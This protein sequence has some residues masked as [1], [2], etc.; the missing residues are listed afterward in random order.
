MAPRAIIFDFDDTL[1][2]HRGAS[3]AAIADWVAARGA[4]GGE[5]A[6]LWHDA[7]NRHVAAWNRGE[8]SF[9]GQRRRRVAEMLLALG[10]PSREDH[11]LDALYDEFLE[12]YRR[13]WRV[14]D[15]VDTTLQ[16]LVD[17]PIPFAVLTNG[18]E[19]LQV[20]K[21]ATVGLTGRIG[22]LFCC[23]AIGH[24]KPDPRSYL[25]V[26][27]ALGVPPDQVLHIGDRYD[28]DVL[29]ARAAGLRALHI[30]RDD[31]GPLDEPD[32]ITSLR[33]LGRFLG[34]GVHV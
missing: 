18:V 29:G 25:V 24:A 10:L 27:D 2:D 32:R 11:E 9:K 13:G 33:E 23:D 4:G 5:F 34:D 3:D 12:L 1:F 7:E 16:L 22:P 31:N 6:E 15:D 14:F 8:I 21:I 19:E 26:C 30:D 28:Y 20:Q 17:A